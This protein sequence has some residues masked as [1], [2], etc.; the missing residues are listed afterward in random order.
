MVLQQVVS[1]FLKDGFA[2][3]TMTAGIIATRAPN[4]VG[5][6]TVLLGKRHAKVRLRLASVSLHPG[7]AMVIMIAEITGTK[8][9]NIVLT[10]GAPLVVGSV[11]IALAASV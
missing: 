9:L 4:S 2:T 1:A 7:C 8:T 3:E 5:T 10:V 6:A 11:P